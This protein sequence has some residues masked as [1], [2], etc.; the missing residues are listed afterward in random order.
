MKDFDMFFEPPAEIRH[1]KDVCYT[2]KVIGG[3]EEYKTYMR[4]KELRLLEEQKAKHEAYLVKRVLLEGIVTG[5]QSA[6]PEAIAVA[7]MNA[8]LERDFRAARKRKVYFNVSVDAP[9]PEVYKPTWFQRIK[10]IFTI[11]L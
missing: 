5:E 8:K 9:P 11:R 1:H 7:D 6:S 10:E 4:A 3:P 2:V